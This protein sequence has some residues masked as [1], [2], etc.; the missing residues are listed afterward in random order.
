VSGWEGEGCV[1]RTRLTNLLPSPRLPR[2]YDDFTSA[3]L[4][5]FDDK[6]IYPPVL[7][8]LLFRVF[9]IKFT[10]PE[11]AAIVSDFD[12][13]GS[14]SVDYSEFLTSFFRVAFA[15]KQ[16]LA[17]E[18]DYAAHKVRDK[19]EREEEVVKK[20]VRMGGGEEEPKKRRY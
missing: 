9:M 5:R 18:Q 7:Q 16:E 13:D 19:M 6:D 14:G 11:C 20:K 4:R 8:D 12:K 3:A 10:L 2:S 15:H 1:Q 17:L